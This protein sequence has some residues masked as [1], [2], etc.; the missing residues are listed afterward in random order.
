MAQFS[1]PLLFTPFLRPLVWGGRNLTALNKTLP[2]PEN[3]GESW[4]LSDHASHSSVV[5]TGPFAG[6]TLRSLIEQHPREILGS[7]GGGVFPWL[8][9]FLDAQDWLSVQV[10]PDDALAKRLRPGELGKTEAWFVLSAEPGSRIYA[11]LK[12][13]TGPNEFRQALAQGTVADLLHSFTPRAGDCVFLPAGTVHA[14]GGGVVL[15]EVQQNSDVTFRLFDWN[16][17]DAQGRS[18]QLHVD[19]GL[20]AVDWNRG[21]VAPVNVPVLGESDTTLSLVQCPQFNLSFVRYHRPTKAPL[22][23]GA[24]KVLIVLAGQA[25][26][27]GEILSPGQVWLLP[28]SLP[29]LVLEPEPFV[30]VLMSAV[31]P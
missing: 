7:A 18:R 22:R 29:D 2:T 30:S 13:G 15:A 4:D 9:K 16:R 3:Y 31:H 14:L 5:A 12:P 10:H 1:A 27:G 17:V 11:G 23:G 6:T 8:I 20:S 24:M 26:L 21:P 28:A 25:R 19:E